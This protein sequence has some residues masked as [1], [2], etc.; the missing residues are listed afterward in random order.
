MSFFLPDFEKASTVF[1]QFWLKTIYESQ[2]HW[3][4]PFSLG[5]EGR[6]L[7]FEHIQPILGPTWQ[8]KEEILHLLYNKPY[9]NPPP[10]QLVQNLPFHPILSP[11]NLW[12][13]ILGTNSHRTWKYMGSTNQHNYIPK[14]Y[15]YTWRIIPKLT[16]RKQKI[17]S[18]GEDDPFH[19]VPA[20]VSLVG[21]GWSKCHPCRGDRFLRFDHQ[22][23]GGKPGGAT[24]KKKG[25]SGVSH[26]FHF[27][28]YL[29]EDSHFDEHIFQM[30]WNHQLVFLK[31]WQEQWGMEN[32]G[33]REFPW[34]FLYIF[35]CITYFEVG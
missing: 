20:F 6:S 25:N 5:F 28:P 18:V 1:G 3:N 29:K 11:K 34:S 35:F 33:E 4:W 30:G 24:T 14:N 26:I 31:V 2:D 22:G 15:S 10:Y 21:G 19:V 32:S 23:R 8:L 16:N 13:N 17:D 12:K 9:R 27:H 7:N